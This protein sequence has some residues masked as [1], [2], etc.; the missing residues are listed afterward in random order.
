MTQET[1][2]PIVL[3]IAHHDPTG[4]SGLAADMEAAASLGCHCA[5]AVTAISVG[6]TREFIGAAPVEDHLLIEQA[7][8][9]L[10]DMPVA[11]IKVGYL[12]ST[13]NIRAI[14]SVLRDYEDIPVIVDPDATLADK[15]SHMAPALWNALVSLILPLATLVA[16]NRR[17]AR[18]MAGEADVLDAQ[19][20][21]LLSSGCEY[22]LMTGVP[23]SPTELQNRLYDIRGLLRTYQWQRLPS[24]TYG[25]CGT[26]T[27]SIACHL[28]HGLPMMEAVARAQKFTWNAIKASRQLGMGRPVPNRFFWTN[29]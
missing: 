4:S 21:E 9:I 5:S 17:E 29:C 28:A 18:A 19:A 10:E 1:N 20:Q 7:R 23:T 25:I 3:S 27:T 6:D 8:A 24:A 22:L 15:E 2:P 16:P 26:L 13:E 11:C 12:G 14:H